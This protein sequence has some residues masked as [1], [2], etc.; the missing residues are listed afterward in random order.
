VVASSGEEDS[1]SATRAAACWLPKLAVL[2]ENVGLFVVFGRG[3]GRLSVEGRR[4]K[5]GPRV[6]RV[7]DQPIPRC[8]QYSICLS[9]GERD[10]AAG[11]A[12]S[13]ERPKE[14]ADTALHEECDAPRALRAAMGGV[15]QAQ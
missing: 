4:G 9:A 15:N 13:A 2:L 8:S 1:R 11:V 10:E 12:S 6:R 7:G 5:P 14:K 3:H